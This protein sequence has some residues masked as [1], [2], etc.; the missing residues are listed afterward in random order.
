[1]RQATLLKNMQFFPE[2]LLILGLRNLNFQ[3]RT[4][5]ITE[6]WYFGLVPHRQLS[7]G[8]VIFLQLI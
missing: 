8:L 3:S 5:L 4:E 6:N 2:I 1:M 7:S